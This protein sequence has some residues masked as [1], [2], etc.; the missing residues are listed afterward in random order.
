MS[1][2]PSCVDVMVLP[3][4]MVI[5]IGAVVTWRST[6]CVSGVHR[7]VVQ[8]VSSIIFDSVGGPKMGDELL[9]AL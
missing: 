9:L 6:R 8:P 5:V 4:G 3:S 7:C 2:C 1:K